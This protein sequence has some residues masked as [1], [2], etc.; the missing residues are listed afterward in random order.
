MVKVQNFSIVT[1]ILLDG[2][3]SG[4]YLRLHL[5]TKNYV[6]FLIV[7]VYLHT[8]RLVPEEAGYMRHPGAG[9]TSGCRQPNMGAGS[10]T[11]SLAGVLSATR[12]ESLDSR[13]QATNTRITFKDLDE[14]FWLPGP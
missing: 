9:V 3:A 10:R 1:K 5:L 6:L 8:W 11:T 2:A 14:H 7:H 13:K 12:L 4:I